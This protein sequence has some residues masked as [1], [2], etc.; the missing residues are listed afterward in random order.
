[1]LPL[2]DKI[3]DQLLGWKADLMTKVGG[4]VQVQFVVT[5][6][7]I[8]HAMALDITQWAIKVEDKIHRGFLWRGESRLEGGG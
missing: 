8:Y 7:I 1:L 4:K 6:S 3:A 5:S 2:I